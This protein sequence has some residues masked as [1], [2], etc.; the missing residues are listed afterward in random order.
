MRVLVTGA[1]GYLG[2][3]VV[4]EL[5]R[6]GHEVVALVRRSTPDQPAVGVR[7]ITFL[8]DAGSEAWE[9]AFRA[10]EA[11]VHLIG[12]IREVPQAGVTFERVHVELTRRGLAAMRTH[13][14]PRLIFVS[15]LGS[16]PHAA[17]LYH[18]T[19]WQAEQAIG[20]QDYVQATILRPSLLFGGGAPFFQTLYQ[21]ARTPLGAMIP[22]RGDTAFAPVF[23]GDVAAMIRAALDDPSASAGLTLEM[24]GPQRFTFDQL[25][26]RVATVR[27]LGPVA[28]HHLPL[29]WLEGLAS[30]FGPRWARFPVT[31]DQ[32]L[33]LNED[34]VTDDV[35]WHRWV[36]PTP[37]G[38]DL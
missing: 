26:D 30:F 19:K 33:M 29:P 27:H 25:I 31:V 3:A 18:R 5:A 6:G 9:D 11:V 24:G 14:V 1:S 7:Y 23:R 17:S 8:E 34:N 38:D 2:R 20:E 32:L 35:R 36:T 21:I 16:R 28:K 4:Q 15:A 13:H 37:M 12:I 10:V 22:G